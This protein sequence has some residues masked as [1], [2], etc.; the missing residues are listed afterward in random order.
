MTEKEYRRS[1]YLRT[2]EHK[3]KQMAERRRKLGIQERP[4]KCRLED[5]PDMPVVQRWLSQEEWAT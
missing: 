1:Y 3:L 5:L 2:R 4:T